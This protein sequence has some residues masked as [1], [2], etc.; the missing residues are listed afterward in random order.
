M[1]YQSES[2]TLVEDDY[3]NP[4]TDEPTGEFTASLFNS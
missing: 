2:N 3:G 4:E 1:E